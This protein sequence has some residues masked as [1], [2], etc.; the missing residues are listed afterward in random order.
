MGI[1][2]KI[3]PMEIGNGR[4]ISIGEHMYK[5]KEE[6]AALIHVLLMLTSILCEINEE[7]EYMT[8]KKL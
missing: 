4:N 3:S 7:L 5:A 6:C 1:E 8:E 2:W